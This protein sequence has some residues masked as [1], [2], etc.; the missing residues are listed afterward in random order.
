MRIPTLLLATAALGSAM[1]CGEAG[2]ASAVDAT[3]LPTSVSCRDLTHLT[4]QAA[5]ARRLSGGGTRD[6]ARIIVGA[7]ATFVASLATIAQL[8]CRTSAA[9]ADVKLEEAL[10]AARAAATTAG[11]YEAAQRWNEAALLAGVAITL[12]VNQIPMVV[13]P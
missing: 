12:L 1:G 2:E 5:D 6:R 11:Q 7:R 10:V 9:E 4:E 8:K 3:P 13:T